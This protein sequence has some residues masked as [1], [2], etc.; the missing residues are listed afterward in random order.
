MLQ[1]EGVVMPTERRHADGM[2]AAAAP[3]V[4]D[5]GP[6]RIPEWAA[7]HASVSGLL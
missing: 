1:A 4:I 7:L 2:G 3:G 5:S 6:Q